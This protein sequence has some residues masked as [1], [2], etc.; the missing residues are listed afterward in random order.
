MFEL[1]FPNNP[2]EGVADVFPNTSSPKKRKSKQSTQRQK[3]AKEEEEGL[4]PSASVCLTAQ[5]VRAWCRRWSRSKQ[6]RSGRFGGTKQPPTSRLSRVR[7]SKER[8]TGVLLLLLLSGLAE[9][10]ERRRGRLLLL[11]LRLSKSTERG[12]RV[13]CSRRSE[14]IRSRL[15]TRLTSESERRFRGLLL[16]RLTKSKAGR[17]RTGGWLTESTRVSSRVSKQASAGVGRGGCSKGGRS[18]RCRRAKEP[19]GWFRGAERRGRSVVG[20]PEESSGGSWGG[21]ES[22]KTGGSR[23]SKAGLGLLLSSLSV[24]LVILQSKFLSKISNPTGHP[25]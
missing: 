8:R 21:S 24:L 9:S 4:T 13:L 17:R 16:T 25:K 6:T 15:G 19:S 1:V 12:G 18:C 10:S 3:S 23:S 7:V 14:R 11:L 5:T 2:P 22:S 20:T